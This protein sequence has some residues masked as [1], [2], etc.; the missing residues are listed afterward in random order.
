MVISS[1][2][3]AGHKCPYCMHQ[4][5]LTGEN[6]LATLRP[7]LVEEWDYEKNAPLLPSQVLSQSIKYVWWKCPVCGHSWKSKIGN[8]FNGRGC[9]NCSQA[10]T[11]FIEQSLYF[12]VKKA[13]PDAL[14]R[15]KFKN[16]EMDIYIPSLLTAI[17]YDGSFYHKSE[18][19]S[20]RETKKDVFCTQNNIRLIRL[21]EKP[22][23]FTKSAINLE[24]D[25]SKWN[26][27][28]KTI[29]D[30]LIFL[31]GNL[32][33]KIDLKKDLPNIITSKRKLIKDRAFGKEFPNLL[34]EWDYEKNLPAIP[35]YFTKG[36]DAKV[37]WKCT[38]GHSYIQSIANHCR[39]T[40]CP[41]CY[42]EKRK[43]GLH[44]KTFF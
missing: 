41:I 38:Q 43:S 15:Y 29:S 26:R 34:N 1:R 27:I 44:K 11:S 21:R 33:D 28:E 20:I 23:P 7:D 17:E 30:L 13:F 4:K 22:L 3:L 25:C 42:G 35:D 12:Y 10:G 36:S 8:R 32:I 18:Y 40:R 2:T 39:G 14:S 19:A 37:W 9:P 31:N 16:V 5:V 24:C 6:D